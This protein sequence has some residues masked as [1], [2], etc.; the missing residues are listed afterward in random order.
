MTVAESRNM[1]V[2]NIKKDCREHLLVQTSF[3]NKCSLIQKEVIAFVNTDGGVI[4]IGNNE[5]A[6]VVGFENVDESHTRLTNGIRD[7]IQQDV[8]LF[9]M[10]CR[11]I[12]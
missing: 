4:Y 8:T 1:L 12:G 3:H 11:M 9:V 6:N 2:A 10:Y 5:Q 7:V